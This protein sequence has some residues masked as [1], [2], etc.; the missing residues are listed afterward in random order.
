MAHKFGEF[1]EEG[2]L[3]MIFEHPKV[4]AT[5]EEIPQEASAADYLH[6]PEGAFQWSPIVTKVSFLGK[7][8]QPEKQVSIHANKTLLARVFNEEQQLVCQEIIFPADVSAMYHVANGNKVPMAVKA[9]F[10]KEGMLLHR[11]KHNIAEEAAFA[12][13]YSNDVLRDV[14]LNEQENKTVLFNNHYWI[15]TGKNPYIPGHVQYV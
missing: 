13:F 6:L 14:R 11:I 2:I 4:F 12:M 15:D 9:V 7:N 3:G 1:S 10:S 8:H 5:L